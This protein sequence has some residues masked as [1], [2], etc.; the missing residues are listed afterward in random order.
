MFN[1]YAR[2]MPDGM[3]SLMQFP[4]VVTLTESNTIEGLVENILNLPENALK[5]GK[6]YW[7]PP[8]HIT[9]FSLS[10]EEQKKGR[11]LYAE[12]FNYSHNKE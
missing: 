5:G 3:F 2:K 11:N 4:G 9:N 1:N 12:R 7:E 8:T 6:I 10:L